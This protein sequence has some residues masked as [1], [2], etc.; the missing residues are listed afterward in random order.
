M[1]KAYLFVL[2]LAMVLALAA[3]ASNGDTSKLECRTDDSPMR[4]CLGDPRVPSVNLKIK[5]LETVPHCVRANPGVPI[6][7]RITPKKGLKVETIEVFPKDE[8]NDWLAGNNSTHEDLI[9]IR[10]PD[11]L[12]PGDYDYGIKTPDDCVD[13]RV[14]VE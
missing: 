12:E 1:K 7:F 5:K 3:V 14:H 11:D 10:V 8:A 4:P 9:I 13:P 6:V 2:P